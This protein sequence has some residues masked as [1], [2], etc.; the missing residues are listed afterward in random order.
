MF[1]SDVMDYKPTILLLLKAKDI[2]MKPRLLLIDDEKGILDS[3]SEFL[4][5][6]FEVHTADNVKNGIKEL[7]SNTYNVAVIDI[8][9]PGNPEGGI[10]IVKYIEI[11]G[12]KTRPIILTGKGTV[13]KFR[14]VFKKVYDFIEKGS[15]DKRASYE[16]LEKALEAVKKQAKPERKP[17]SYFL[18][19]SWKNSK[20]ADHVELLLRRNN[21]KVLRDQVTIRAGGNIPETVKDMINNSETFLA[22]WSKNYNNEKSRWCLRELEYADSRRHDKQNPYRII[23]LALDQTK[24]IP[25]N[26]VNDLRLTARD[27]ASRELAIKKIIE[28]ESV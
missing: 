26:A 27:P 3:Y 21:I 14:K 22:L 28:Q 17:H 4:E 11:R 6:D 9:F 12:L 24:D 2:Y 19:Y 15:P 5:D 7:S 18:S 16:V 25:L 1:S 10:D 13:K 23:L 8:D 20:I